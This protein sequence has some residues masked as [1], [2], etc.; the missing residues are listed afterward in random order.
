MR[1]RRVF[2]QPVKPIDSYQRLTALRP[3]PAQGAPRHPGRALS[4]PDFR[5]A[6]VANAFR[7]ARSPA[8]SKPGFHSRLLRERYDPDVA[9]GVVEAAGG[10]LSLEDG[11]GLLSFAPLPESVLESLPE[12]DLDLD[13]DSLP[14]ELLSDELPSEELLFGA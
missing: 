3:D 7:P 9:E 10:L 14:G 8:L 6:P 5:H 4:K 13:P 11:A 2:P 1:S 12:S